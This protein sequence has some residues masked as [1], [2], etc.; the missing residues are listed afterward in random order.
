MEKEVSFFKSFFSSMQVAGL[1]NFPILPSPRAPSL[2]SSLG[3]NFVTFSCLLFSLFPSLAAELG[4]ELAILAEHDILHTFSPVFHSGFAPGPTGYF[5]IR[6]CL[7]E[8]GRE[9]KLLIKERERPFKRR[10]VNF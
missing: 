6:L 5:F 4:Y 9:G 10:G 2:P 7:K 1:V 8:R 3:K